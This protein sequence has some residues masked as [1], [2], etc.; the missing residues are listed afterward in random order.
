MANI[1]H[2][3]TKNEKNIYFYAKNFSYKLIFIKKN[4]ISS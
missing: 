2:F 3:I 1:V 4:K